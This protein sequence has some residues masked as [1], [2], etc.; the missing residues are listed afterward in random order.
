IA[1]KV[2]IE[3]QEVAPMRV[4]LKLRRTSIDRTLSVVIALKNA[5]QPARDLLSDLIKIHLM[6]RAGGA[7]YCK[8]V[9]VV[10]VILQQ[11]SDDQ[12]VDRHPNGTA[13]VR[14]SAKHAGIGFRWQI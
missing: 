13:P 8:V 6:T 5:H 3:Q 7:L 12:S 10:R 14:V 9:A 2:L 4:V 1:V 11:R